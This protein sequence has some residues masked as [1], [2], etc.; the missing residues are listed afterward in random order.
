MCVAFKLFL[1]VLV[2]SI[3]VHLYLF[4]CFLAKIN[5][6]YMYN[7]YSPFYGMPKYLLLESFVE[8]DKVGL[9]LSS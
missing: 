7:M 1:F 2:Y 4:I 6:Y 8:I 3:S 5:V 9:N